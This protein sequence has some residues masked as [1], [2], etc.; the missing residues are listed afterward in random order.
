[1]KR[2][3]VGLVLIFTCLGLVGCAGSKVHTTRFELNPR[4]GKI[5]VMPW[6]KAKKSLSASDAKQRAEMAQEAVGILAGPHEAVDDATGLFTYTFNQDDYAN[7]RQSVIQ[8]LIK[9]EAFSDVIDVSDTPPTSDDLKL[10]LTFSKSGIVQTPATS[11]CILNG[12]AR[13][14]KDTDDAVPTR[15]IA[16]EATSFLSVNGA[17]NKAIKEYLVEIGELLKSLE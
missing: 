4:K 12:L 7:L 14:V 15:K 6:E 5:A 9:S 1:M 10:I 17:K 8:S 2:I 13:I 11:K 16:I 3:I